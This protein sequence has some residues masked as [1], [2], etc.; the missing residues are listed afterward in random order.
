[1]LDFLLLNNFH[2]ENE[3]FLKALIGTLEELI[4]HVREFQAHFL[5]LV[6]GE[7]EHLTAVKGLKSETSDHILSSQAFRLG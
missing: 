2:L 3:L 6:N 4:I 1:L 5:H 7:D